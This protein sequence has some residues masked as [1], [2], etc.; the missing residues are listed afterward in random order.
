MDDLKSFVRAILFPETTTLRRKL[1]N[2]Q[3]CNSVT[4]AVL[5]SVNRMSPV[6]WQAKNTARVPCGQ[7]VWGFSKFF[8]R[9]LFRSA[10]FG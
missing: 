5:R 4:F 8:H 6:D 9:N 1:F 3:S 2:L 10:F 7:D